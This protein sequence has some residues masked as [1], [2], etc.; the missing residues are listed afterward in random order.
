MKTIT[1]INR[2]YYVNVCFSLFTHG[3]TFDFIQVSTGDPGWFGCI[4]APLYFG[5]PVLLLLETVIWYKYMTDWLIDW[6]DESLGILLKILTS[7]NK[8]MK[9]LLFK[10]PWNWTCLKLGIHFHL[11]YHQTLFLR[12]DF[13]KIC[14]CRE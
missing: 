3:A 11:L 2:P 14:L 5:D 6:C 12:Y 4:E 10:N 9:R 7:K 13:L 8:D 1:N